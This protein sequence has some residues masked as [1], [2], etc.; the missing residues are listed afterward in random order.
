[1]WWC[2]CLAF[3]SLEPTLVGLFEESYFGERVLMSE[4][5]SRMAVGASRERFDNMSFVGTVRV[6][7]Y[8]FEQQSWSLLQTLGGD[9]ANDQFGRGLSGNR[10]LSRL[11]IGAIY[12]SS[13]T[14]QNQGRVSIFEETISKSW[15]RTF[16]IDGSSAQD[17]FGYSLSM[18][19]SGESFSV[20]TG[21]SSRFQT[22]QRVSSAAGWTW[23]STY[24]E[25]S[26][27]SQLGRGLFHSESCTIVGAPTSFEQRGAAKVVVGTHSDEWKWGLPNS[28]FGTS[29]ASTPLCETIVV[30]A[31]YLGGTPGFGY[32]S[33]F[34]WSEALGWDEQ[35]TFVSDTKEDF[36]G[37][38]V[39]M[40]T[41]GDV[42]A[43]GAPYYRVVGTSYLGKVF[44]FRRCE[45]QW[46]LVQEIQGV[47]ANSY[48]GIGESVG[49]SGDGSVLA[50]GHPAYSTS[51]NQTSDLRGAVFVVETR[52]CAATPAPPLPDRDSLNIWGVV[53]VIAL[54]LLFVR[55]RGD[56]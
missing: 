43:V 52:R 21:L 49:L 22:F 53:L 2:A 45:G 24:E 28:S 40:S 55:L 17:Y 36:L 23:T 33:I 12:H 50:Y 5:G 35:W 11:V 4:D 41:S 51:Q 44:V 1:M 56:V 13:S 29:L 26:L 54:F 16:S 9:H 48:N 46:S 32:V 3:A 18:D 15:T 39:A 20:G 7:E 14:L 19:R 10:D 27:N 30:G 31:P 25:F 34:E 6:F 38:H 47:D 8:D 42:V 37:V